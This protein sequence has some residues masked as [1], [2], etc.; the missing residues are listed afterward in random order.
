[1]SLFTLS[2]AELAWGEAPL[3]DHAAMSL[4]AGERVGLIGRN[5]TGKSSLLKVIARKDKLD[6]GELIVQDGLRAVY[7]EQEPQLP[8]ADTFRESLV[9]RGGLDDIAD[10]REKWA[11]LARLEEY[12][13]RLKLPADGSP[14]TASGGEKKRAA[15]ALALSLK[16]DLLL[17]DEPTN[18]LDIETILVLEGILTSEYKN[19]RSLMVITHDRAFLD[20]TVTRIVELDR[21]ALRS[22]PG[23]FAAYETR[24]AEELAAEAVE[25][26][27]FDKF[28][29]QEEVWIRK[30]IEARRTRNEGRV[31]RLEALRRER[32]ARRERMGSVNLSIDAGEK[33]GKIVAE[34]TGLT[35]SFG[36]RTIVKDLN[37]KL[38]RGDK[39]GLLGHN[40]TGKS[41]L[42]KLLLGELAPDAGTV[43]LGTNLNIAYFDQLREQLD[44]TKTVAETISPGSDWVE[45]AGERKHIMSYLAD[46]LFT[47]QRASV[48]VG[49]LSGGERN[50]LLLARLF[51]LPA[52]LLVLDEPTNDLDIDSLELLEATLETYPGTL[53]LVSHD[54]R[55]LDDVVTQVLAPVNPAEPDGRWMEFVGGYEDWL[56]Q[57][58][59]FEAEKPKAPEKPREKPQREVKNAP[60]QRVRMSFKETK[61]LESLPQTIESLEAEQSDLMTAMSAPDYFKSEP[62]RQ[63]ADKERMDA[64]PGLIEAAYARWEELTAKAEAANQR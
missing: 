28:H 53:I 56:R 24:K 48:P 21:G 2:D 63:K 17:L 22:Y 34:V 3:L 36:D 18:H 26:A 27:R 6:D 10:D 16:P 14:A 45:I 47:P 55:F 39:L 20:D 62:A 35:K 9:L 29:A 33:S 15:L 59:A 19:G 54:R 7:V 46:F 42:I 1:M 60:P 4:E 52:N 11:A 40:G 37:F 25:R 32:A 49:N 8:P 5:G 57:R 58:P 61:E 38:M 41:T 13:Q 12:L 51:A 43:K 23:N 44:D 30:G 31:R 64:L 50:R